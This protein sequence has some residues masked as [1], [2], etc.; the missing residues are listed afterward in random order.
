MTTPGAS[1]AALPGARGMARLCAVQALYQ[2][3]ISGAN[4]RPVIDEFIGFRM[5]GEIDEGSEDRAD[6]D[7]FRDVVSGVDARDAEIAEAVETALAEG[8]S[9]TRLDTTL[10][11]IL[12]A[13]TYEL[14][15]RIDVP[16]RVVINEY[17]EL[18][19]AFFEGPEPGF[20]NAVLDRLGRVYRSGEMMNLNDVPAGSS[21]T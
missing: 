17:V 1:E 19:A 13:A 11:Q 7:F 8:W 3:E 10:R 16:A 5:G 14:I 15:A 12:R 21:Q 18:T 4:F 2:I 20:V 6:P 9:Y